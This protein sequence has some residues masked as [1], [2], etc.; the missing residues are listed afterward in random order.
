MNTP[1]QRAFR[2][3]HPDWDPGESPG[4]TLGATGSVAMI[5]GDA[6]VRQALLLLLSTRP[7]ERIMRPTYGCDLQRLV[8]SPNDDTTAGLAI[9]YV[10]QAIEQWEHRIRILKLDA[11]REAEGPERLWM[12]LDYEVRETRVTGQVTWTLPLDQEGR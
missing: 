5:Q 6:S 9:H 11:G 7:G 12:R 1:R 8:F 2:F 10:R 4:L 3:A